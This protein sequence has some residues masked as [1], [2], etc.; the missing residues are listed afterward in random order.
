MPVEPELL[1]LFTDQ[2]VVTPYASTKDVYGRETYT[3]GTSRTL[4]CF[5]ERRPRMMQ[6]SEGRTVIANATIYV[7]DVDITP[8]D[9]ITYANGSEAHIVTIFVPRDQD[10]PHHSEIT[11]T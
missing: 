11:V 1:E 10:G 9:R 2:I 8:N 3:A 7:D 4:A 6:T 5:I